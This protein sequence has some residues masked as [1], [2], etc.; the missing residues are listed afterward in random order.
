MD[1]SAIKK[2]RLIAIITLVV[3]FGAWLVSWL[4][5]PKFDPLTFTK[6]PLSN[7]SLTTIQ[8]DGRLYTYNGASFYSYSPSDPDDIK[9]L[10]TGMRLPSI[11]QLYWAGDKGALAVFGDGQ[12]NSSEVEA[13]LTKQDLRYGNNAKKFVWYVDFQSREISIVS[14]EKIA[15]ETAYYDASANGFYFSR[16]GPGTLEGDVPTFPLSFYDIGKKQTSNVMDNIQNNGVL[17]YIGNCGDKVCV[18]QKSDD[19]QVLWS[20]ENGSKKTLSDDYNSLYATN[21]PGVFVGGKTQQPSGNEANEDEFLQDD[22]F[23]VDVTNNSAKSLGFSY[24]P[25]GG[26]TAYLSKDNKLSIIDTSLLDEKNQPMYVGVTTDIFGNQKTKAMGIQSGD[27]NSLNSHIDTNT[28]TNSSGSSIQRDADGYPVLFSPQPAKY[29]EIYN[30]N[31]LTNALKPCL[32]KTKSN[33]YSE[34]LQTLTVGINYDDKFKQNVESFMNC[35][36]DTDKKAL[37]GQNYIFIGQDPAT[38]RFETN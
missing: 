21:K 31:Q 11:D 23:L 28:Q 9:V 19:K 33:S 1:P 5:S 24:S 12:S 20:V 13:Q 8:D 6:L 10:L 25:G 4:V 38:G 37:L 16:F 3:I 36:R 35:I 18:I 22:A 2:L 17:S 15:A 14:R 27:G 32:G 30:S 26:I 29:F 34:D 7:N